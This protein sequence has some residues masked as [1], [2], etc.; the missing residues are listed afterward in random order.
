MIMAMISMMSSV[1]KTRA[2]NLW[3]WKSTQFCLKIS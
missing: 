2:V 1:D 3:H